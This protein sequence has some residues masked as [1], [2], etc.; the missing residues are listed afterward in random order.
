MLY[1]D[2][3]RAKTSTILEN[4]NCRPL[5]MCQDKESMFA[6]LDAGADPNLSLNMLGQ[7][8]IHMHVHYFSDSNIIEKYKKYG[9]EPNARDLNQQTALHYAISFPRC[10][11]YLL[12]FGCDPNLIDRFGRTPLQEARHKISSRET[13]EA[14]VEAFNINKSMSDT[15]NY[16]LINEHQKT[17]LEQR[18]QEIVQRRLELQKHKT[19]SITQNNSTSAAEQQLSA[20]AT[21]YI[22]GLKEQ[23]STTITRLETE[24]AQLKAQVTP[25]LILTEQVKYLSERLDKYE[26]SIIQQP[27]ILYK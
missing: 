8:L 6:L 4:Y 24:I 22:N 10:I 5:G 23:F 2:P 12:E 15:T 13:Y 21:D 16:S 25:L 27:I 11:K 9:V 7:K 20:E 19:R 1:K 3:A 14:I 18:K 26:T 17:K